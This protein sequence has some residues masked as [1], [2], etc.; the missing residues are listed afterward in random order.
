MPQLGALF[1]VLALWMTEVTA[2][3]VL[4]SARPAARTDIVSL[5]ACVVLATSIVIFV[6][7]RIHAPH[8]SLRALL[9]VRGIGPVRAF[10]AA[11][12]GAGLAP[13]VSSLE[14]VILRR[15]PYADAEVTESFQRLVASSSR[16]ALV[17]GALVVV[18]VARELFF[19]GL[20]FGRL[21]QRRASL[22][23]MPAP[24]RRWRAVVSTTVLFALFSAALDPREVP[25]ALLLG[26]A[27]ARLRDRTGS[28]LA[29]VVAHLAYG[30]V[31]AIPILLGR[32]PTANVTY[33]PRWVLGGAIIAALAL[34]AVGAGGQGEAGEGDEAAGGEGDGDRGVG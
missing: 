31:D 28:V 1:W 30:A 32:D 6:A 29:P 10:L 25:T 17:A 18:P 3:A 27:F 26:F 20:I 19:R 33:A 21:L 15:W 24:A 34:A 8:G 9:A 13:L 2:Q 16:L 11:S 5:S 12:A 4:V 22:E 23:P 14:D 7:A